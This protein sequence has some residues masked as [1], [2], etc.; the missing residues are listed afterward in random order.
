MIFRTTFQ[1][2]GSLSVII[3]LILV[4]AFVYAIIGISL[5]ASFTNSTTVISKY[6]WGFKNLAN[7]MFMLFQL[8]TLDQ[9]DPVLMDIAK[10]VTPG[11]AYAYIITWIWLGAFIFRNIFIGIIVTDFDRIQ[12]E[13]AEQEMEIA[14]QKK[15]EKMRKKLN[16][17]LENQDPLS[18]YLRID[19]L[20]ILS[21]E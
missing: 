10:V 9:W 18:M 19:L 12:S 16:R 4:I 7:A 15:F 13:M 14:K 8:L 2:L 11:V 1:A 5:F 6:Q 21:I 20:D 3:M 17:R